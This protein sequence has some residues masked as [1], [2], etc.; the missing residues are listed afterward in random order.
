MKSTTRIQFR[1]TKDEK[2]RLRSYATQLGYKTL[3]AFILNSAYE[4]IR[5]ETVL[6]HDF[7]R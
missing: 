4:K 5:E 7:F 3:S 1:C 2:D 6:S